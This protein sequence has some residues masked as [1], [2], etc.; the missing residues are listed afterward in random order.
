M[1][2]SCLPRRVSVLPALVTLALLPT[3]AAASFAGQVIYQVMPDRFFNG[4]KTNDGASD[5]GNP[6]AWHGGDLAGLGSKL[7]Y[8]NKLGVSAVWL[9][10]IYQQQPGRSFDTDGY[11]GYWPADFRQV[12][13]HFGTQ[14][15]WAAFVKAAHAGGLKVV[16]D[17]VINHFGYTAPA[18]AQHPEWF[19]T[20][21]DC[22]AAK[23]KDVVCPLAGLPD[24]KQE[25]P[26]VRDFLFGNDDD[27][28]SQGVDAY[29][30]DAIKNVPDDFLGALLARDR[31]AGSW[32][33]GESYG[34]DALTV[35][36]QQRLGFDSL[37]DFQLQ[38]AMKASIMGGSTLARVR[39]ALTELAKVP[40]PDE[41]ALFLDNHDLP[42]FAQGTLFEDLGQAR[43]KYGLRALMT[44]RGVP[45][46]WQGTEIAMRGGADPDNRRDMRFES[47]WTPAEQSVFAVASNAVGVRRASKALSLGDQTLLDVPDKLSDQLLLFMRE[48]KASGQRVLVA[49]H[50]GEDRASYS[51]K[52][53]LPAQAL[54]RGLFLDPGESISSAK[55]SVRGGYLHLSLPPKTAM[56]FVL[57]P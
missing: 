2:R 26:A 47:Q 42:R 12:D 6:R 33:L 13:S 11:H 31:A 49:W 17:Q 53:S 40:Q 48:D 14:A 18:V 27:W 29:R 19:H 24:L 10:P 51:L 22:D 20:Q 46:I 15:E 54:T 39:S 57:K 56:A 37:F 9:T 35:G 30:Y 28:R 25:T 38:D 4:D 32:T 55:L 21:A 8:L 23:D 41:V 45:V 7:G 3:A 36:Q 52:S 1:S 50:G 44:L 34:A 16:L 43:T 5:P